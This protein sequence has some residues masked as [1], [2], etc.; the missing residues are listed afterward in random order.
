MREL[1]VGTDLTDLVEVVI[2]ADKDSDDDYYVAVRWKHADNDGSPRTADTPNENRVFLSAYV[3]EFR[4]EGVIQAS[5]EAEV[6][7]TLAKGD[8]TDIEAFLEA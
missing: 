4:L 8:I 1:K 7:E 2:T 6:A 5:E 3:R